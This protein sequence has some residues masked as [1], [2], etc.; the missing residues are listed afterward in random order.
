MAQIISK[1]LDA[2][3]ANVKLTLVASAANI[4][5]TA[6]GSP[7]SLPGD[8]RDPSCRF[9][10]YIFFLPETKNEENRTM[11]IL[12][13]CLK[14]VYKFTLESTRRRASTNFKHQN[15]IENGIYLRHFCTHHQI[16]S[17]STTTH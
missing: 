15:N 2:I 17:S 4:W 6:G 13:L 10:A 12:D 9:E 1:I 8:H 7:G 16:F 3:L 5:K 14:I 11:G